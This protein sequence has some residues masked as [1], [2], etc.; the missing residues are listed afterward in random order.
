MPAATEV[1]LK[2]RVPSNAYAQLVRH[3][4]LT[5]GRA[6]ETHR[7]YAIYFDTPG[8]DLWRSGL[9]LR[10]RRDGTSWTQ[11]LKGAGSAAAG[12]HARLELDT[13]VSTPVPDLALFA[14][15]SWTDK[16]AAIVADQ[17]LQ[18][19]CVTQFTRSTRLLRRAPDS[20]IEA[21]VDRGHI[22]AGRVREPLCEL[23][24]ELK[25]GAPQA[26]YELALELLD[27]FPI[28]V[29]NRS[30][31]E[32][33]YALHAGVHEAPAKGD[34]V[35]LAPTMTVSDAISAVVRAVMSHVQA[36]DS[37]LLRHS[38]PE[39]VHQMRVGLR[40]LRSALSVFR[41]VLDAAS[42]QAMT[43]EVR[44]LARMLGTARDWDVF[45]ETAYAQPHA[46][47]PEHAG[48]Q[49]YGREFRKRQRLARRKA[50]RAVASARYQRLVLEI[51]A[52][53]HAR[54]W[55]NA[56]NPD[57]AQALE[58]PV[59]AYAAEVLEARYARLRKRG[60]KVE[61]HSLQELHELRIAAKKLRYAA[62]FFAGLYDGDRVEALLTHLARLQ[63]A[64][65]A[66]NDASSVDALV[67][68]ATPAGP[69]EEI[70]EARGIL[71]A[72]GS[73]QAG[74]LR[75][76]AERA[77]RSLRRCPTFW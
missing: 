69:L 61:Q 32:R 37:G 57:A 74:L 70:A 46:A 19:V 77:W 6:P 65:G 29:E 75:R 16:V 23:E 72:W 2:L 55:R 44:W 54:G 3:P 51:G 60:R 68:A 25:A 40:R 1:E 27:F 7:L 30:K 58:Q 66:L 4:A 38:D 48:I 42:S 59:M 17:P 64:L 21:S 41:P 47:F 24:L 12:L 76:E 20:L 67:Q 11:T 15:G 33:G 53:L 73:G 28:A 5:D 35:A 43:A 50:Q 14:R 10:V 62:H 71:L 49:A 39:Y 45:M 34:A 18:R 56:P 36:N 31:A 9:A 13:P 63:D 22:R 26:L 8:D 52:L